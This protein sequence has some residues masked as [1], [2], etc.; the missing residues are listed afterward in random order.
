MS[1]NNTQDE[2]SLEVDA[3]MTSSSSTND[4]APDVYGA[5][6]AGSDGDDSSIH[7]VDA[8]WKF[9]NEHR[10]VSGVDEVNLASLRRRIDWHIVP[11]MFCCYT[12]QFLDKVIYNVSCAPSSRLGCLRPQPPVRP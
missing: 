3:R 1:V 11:L 4:K 10:D 12:M 8:A 5:N 7:E 9:L 6:K 2:K